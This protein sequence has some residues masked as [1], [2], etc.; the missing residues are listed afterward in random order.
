MP[1]KIYRRIRKRGVGFEGT[2]GCTHLSPARHSFLGCWEPALKFPASSRGEAGSR[3]RDRRENRRPSTPIQQQPGTEPT[4]DTDRATQER[5]EAGRGCRCSSAT[6][7]ASRGLGSPPGRVQEG[8]SGRQ[9]GPSGALPRGLD[10][11]SHPAAAVTGSRLQPSPPT[12]TSGP[13]AVAEAPTP[14]ELAQS[15]GPPSL[16]ARR[17]AVDGRGCPL[18]A[19]LPRLPAAHATPTAR[20]RRRRARPRPPGGRTPP[21]LGLASPAQSPLR[22]GRSPRGGRTGGRPSA[23]DRVAGRA[24]PGSGGGGGGGGSRHAPLRL[25]RPRGPFL[26][27]EPGRGGGPGLRA[28]GKRRRAWRFPGQPRG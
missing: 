13:G 16:S 4:G 14:R 12:G 5:P 11:H 2:R 1:R 22:G 17:E 26:R 18:S 15:R 6:R 3:G 24:S 28:P 27:A 8:A 21:G 19:L 23:A 7:R 9:A 25:R 20:G 10:P